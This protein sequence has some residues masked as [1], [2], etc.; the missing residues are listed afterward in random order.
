MKTRD[1][2]EVHAA[3]QQT[4]ERNVAGVLVA[5]LHHA[6]KELNRIRHALANKYAVRSLTPSE[7]ATN[8]GDHL[9]DVAFCIDALESMP[10]DFLAEVHDADV[11]EEI[12]CDDEVIEEAVKKDIIDFLRNLAGTD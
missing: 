3:V 6:E 4:A 1:R 7:D 9:I 12:G 5:A 2:N 11:Y 8:C 10:L